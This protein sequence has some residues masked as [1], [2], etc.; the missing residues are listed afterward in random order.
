MLWKVKIIVKVSRN[1]DHKNLVRLDCVST[2]TNYFSVWVRFLRMWNYVHFIYYLY[3][4]LV[5][6]LLRWKCRYVFPFL[7][8]T[9][10]TRK[11]LR[12]LSRSWQDVW[13][14]C[15]RTS[16]P[17]H[18]TSNKGFQ[19]VSLHIEK[20]VRISDVNVRSETRV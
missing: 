14:R 13:P 18:V 4:R 8:W 20:T 2:V 7:R 10:L 3:R 15:G 1:L 12:G 17:L 9:T 19:V 16:G 6:V 11:V 5:P